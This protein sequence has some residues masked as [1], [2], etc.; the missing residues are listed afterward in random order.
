MAANLKKG[1]QLASVMVSK[2][3]LIRLSHSATPIFALFTM[4]F[5]VA[6]MASSFLGIDMMMEDTGL[7]NFA[8]L[9]LLATMASFFVAE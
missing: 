9:F 5:A 2:H 7:Y 6:A 8:L 4:A 3:D 1:E